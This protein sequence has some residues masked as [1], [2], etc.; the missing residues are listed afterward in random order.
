MGKVKGGSVLC[1]HPAE[2]SVPSFPAC[3]DLF[4]FF[5]FCR[6]CLASWLLGHFGRLKWVASAWSW[7]CV[8]HRTSWLVHFY[9]WC[10]TLGPLTHASLMNGCTAIVV[11]ARVSLMSRV[12][13]HAHSPWHKSVN[14]YVFN[15]VFY[16]WHPAP[17]KIL[18]SLS[19][20]AGTPEGELLSQ[21]VSQSQGRNLQLVHFRER[22]YRNFLGTVKDWFSLQNSLKNFSLLWMLFILGAADVPK[23]LCISMCEKQN[24][25]KEVI[26]TSSQ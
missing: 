6:S 14:D 24:I 16:L 18:M 11:D 5:F 22:C 19:G 13:T 10:G 21:G 2:R 8:H 9:C 17:L 4:F 7:L 3:W 12:Y 15:K 25:T 23:I 26:L 1:C 20:P